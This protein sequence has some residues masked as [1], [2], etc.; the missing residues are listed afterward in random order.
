MT[1]KVYAAEIERFGPPGVII[2]SAYQNRKGETHA[3]SAVIFPEEQSLISF[4]QLEFDRTSFENSPI[5]K[6]EEFMHSQVLYHAKTNLDSCVRSRYGEDFQSI[7]PGGLKLKESD[8]R[9]LDHCWN[10]P[11]KYAFE[12]LKNQTECDQLKNELTRIIR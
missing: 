4:Y 1:F 10:R 6:K 5:A 7:F 9:L 12:D 2:T 11:Q 3:E 8:I